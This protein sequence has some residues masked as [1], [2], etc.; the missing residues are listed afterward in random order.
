MARGRSGSEQRR[1]HTHSGVA[2]SEVPAPGEIKAVQLDNQNPPSNPAPQAAA[3]P[4][5]DAAAQAEMD[6]AQRAQR[7]TSWVSLSA[8]E[9]TPAN[10]GLLRLL[11]KV[12]GEE[13]QYIA[14]SPKVDGFLTFSKGR[15]TKTR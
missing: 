11:S 13:N 1:G 12:F 5:L 6:A 7:R 14:S 3:T 2:T 10:R 9:D 4:P 8:Q 15:M